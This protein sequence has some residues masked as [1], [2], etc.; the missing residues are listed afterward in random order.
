[1]GDGVAGRGDR[2][3]LVRRP[4][5]AVSPW[6]RSGEKEPGGEWSR[7]RRL[8]QTPFRWEVIQ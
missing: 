4:G 8:G 7:S 6:G 5:R 1:M 2:P 3:G